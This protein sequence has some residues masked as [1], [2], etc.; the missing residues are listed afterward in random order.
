MAATQCI[1]MLRFKLSIKIGKDCDL[2]DFENGMNGLV[3][4]FQKLWI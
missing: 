2:R 1:D 4:V 3:R